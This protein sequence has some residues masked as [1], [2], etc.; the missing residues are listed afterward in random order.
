MVETH[1]EG[2]KSDLDGALDAALGL[3][4]TPE[5]NG[6]LRERVLARVGRHRSPAG[7]TQRAGLLP[8]LLVATATLAGLGFL[9]LW[10]S[11]PT[12]APPSQRLI[13]RSESPASVQHVPPVAGAHAP[14]AVLPRQARRSRPSGPPAESPFRRWAFDDEAE[15]GP[16]PL[17]QLPE[18]APVVVEELVIAPLEFAPLEV[19][20]LSETG[21][22]GNREP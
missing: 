10:R 9:L 5:P 22:E 11:V 3:L 20:P 17:P 18:P 7:P 14:P 13:T 1:N 15:G 21:P 6:D 4:A 19:V 12:A 16:E 8:G 2:R